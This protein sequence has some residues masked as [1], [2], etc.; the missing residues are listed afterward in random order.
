M[1]KVTSFFKGVWASIP[2]ENKAK[3]AEAVG[4]VMKAHHVTQTALTEAIMTQENILAFSDLVD[5]LAQAGVGYV[6]S[7]TDKAR[8]ASGEIQVAVEQGVAAA[9]AAN[10]EMIEELRKDIVGE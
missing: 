2:T 5:S 4:K 3:I 7:L 1:S 10:D 9:N 6:K 8:S